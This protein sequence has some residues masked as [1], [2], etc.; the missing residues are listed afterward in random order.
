[1]SE[2][3]PIYISELVVWIC[4]NPKK[5]PCFNHP[6]FSP[7]KN[8]NILQIHVVFDIVCYPYA[9]TIYIPWYCHS[10]RY[11]ELYI[12]VLQVGSIVGAY[13]ATRTDDELRRELTDLDGLQEGMLRQAMENHHF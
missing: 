6:I 5:A 4:L 7:K 10:P 2:V 1:M 9:I 13:V 12:P 11:G 8:S 3:Y